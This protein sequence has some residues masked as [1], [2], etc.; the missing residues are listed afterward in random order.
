MA[1][2]IDTDTGL[3]VDLCVLAP[4]E[5]H[6]Q[7]FARRQVLEIGPDRVPCY[8]VSPEDIILMKLAWRKDTRSAKQWENALGVARVKGARMDWQYLFE[9]AFTLGIEN[10]LE[11]LR[12]EAG[13]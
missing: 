11:R 10:D 1:N 13:I 12:D 4:S 6:D 7:V 3:T 5:F 2:L 9:Q 8:M